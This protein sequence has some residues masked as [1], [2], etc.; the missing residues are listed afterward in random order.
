MHGE[1]QE[2]LK[3]ENANFNVGKNQ[4]GYP[5]INFHKSPVDMIS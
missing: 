1:D 5:E 2:V 4:D 3:L